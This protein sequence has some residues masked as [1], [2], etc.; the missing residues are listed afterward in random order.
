MENCETNNKIIIIEKST[1]DINNFIQNIRKK[2]QHDND[3]KYRHLAFSIKGNI[4]LFKNYIDNPW[5]VPQVDLYHLAE[6]PRETLL[7]ICQHFDCL[8]S[9]ESLDELFIKLGMFKNIKF[10]YD[11]NALLEPTRVFIEDEKMDIN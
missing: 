4:S 11:Y 10:C 3:L 2:D 5:S 6:I 7:K 8:P 9:Y 1:M